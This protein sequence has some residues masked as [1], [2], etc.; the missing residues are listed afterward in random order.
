[1]LRR[2]AVQHSLSVLTPAM[3]SDRGYLNLV[4]HLNAHTSSLPLE[5]LNASVAH[6][7]A[8]AQPSATPLA[9]SVVSSPRFSASFS[10]TILEGLQ[11]AFR[12]ALHVKIKVITGEPGGIFSRGLTAQVAEWNSQVLKGLQGGHPVL[13]LACYSGLLFG[14][15]DHEKKL[16]MQQTFPRRRVEEELVI[17]LAEII[18]FVS[19]TADAWE[20][21]FRTHGRN[22]AGMFYVVYLGV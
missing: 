11:T 20:A 4:A 5:T 15:N 10:F 3:S 21:E 18:D 17:A 19:P 9:A 14:L 1:M 2:A 12:H 6:Y 7:L 8:R 16:K 13:R 22:T